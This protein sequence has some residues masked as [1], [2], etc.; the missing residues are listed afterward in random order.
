MKEGG[1][2]QWHFDSNDFSITLLLQEAEQGGDFKYAPNIRTP[3]DENYESVARLLD[4]D[5]KSVTVKSVPLHA[6]TLMI[7]RGK[8]SLHRAMPVH[9]ARQRIQSVLCFDVEAGRTNLAATNR[10]HYVAQPARY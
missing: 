9:G 3:K 4:G 6:G 10:R 2:Q 8:Y 5:E 7:F 1:E